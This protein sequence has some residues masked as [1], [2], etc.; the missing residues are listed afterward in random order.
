MPQLFK[1]IDPSLATNVTKF[2]NYDSLVDENQFLKTVNTF[3]ILS[4]S[5]ILFL[6]FIYH[7]RTLKNGDEKKI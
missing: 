3:I 2:G 4:V 5:T 1:T 6:S 7:S